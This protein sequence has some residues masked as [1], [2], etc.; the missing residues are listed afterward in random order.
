MKKMIGLVLWGLAGL[1]L[2]AGAQAATC[3]SKATGAWSSGATWTCTGTPIVAIPGATDTAIIASPNVVTLA[4][5]IPVTNLTVDTGA[6]LADAGFTLTIT[7]NLTNNGTI[8]GTGRMNVTGAASVIS[9]VGAYAGSRLYVSGAAT[10]IAAGAVLNFSGASR[11][12]VGRS[13][14]GT[15]VATSVLT[16]NGTINSTIPTA[17][18]A[19]LRLYANSTVIGGTGIINA[20]VSA[21][22]YNAATA[23][24]TN[25]GSVSVNKITQNAATNAWTQGVNSGLTVTAISTVGVLNASA[26]GN[27]VTYTSPATPIAPSANAY[28]NLAGTGVTCPTAFTILGSSPC[29]VTPGTVTVTMNPG[30]CANATGI[31][32]AAWAPSPTTNVNLSDALYATASINGT[33]NYLRCSGYGFAVP[34]TATILG[35]VVNVTRKSSS[36]T[37]TTDGAMRLVKGGAVGLTDRSTAT[38]YTTADVIEAHGTSADLWGVAWTPADINLAT[39]GAAFAAKSTKSRI[40]SVNYMPISVT[41]SAPPAAPHHIQIVHSGS[42][43]TCAPEQLTVKACA[44]AACTANFNGANVTGNVTWAGAPGGTLPFSLASGGTGQATISLSVTTAQTVTLGTSAVVPAPAA[45]SGCTNLAG[46]AACS[47][48]F[49]A[50][51]GCLDAVEVGAAVGTTIFTKLAGTAFSLDVKTVSGAN[52]GTVAVPVPV[53]VELVNASAGSCA[54]FAQLSAQ[55]VNFANVNKMTVPF[56]AYPSAVKNTMV[57]MTSGGSASCSSDGFAIRPVTLAITSSANADGTGTSLTATPFKSGAPFTLTA[58]AIAGYDG[59]PVIDNAQVAPHTGANAAGQLGVNGVVLSPANGYTGFGVAVAATGAATGSAYTYDEVGYFRFNINGVNDK[60]FAS[61]D[62]LDGDCT[63]DFSNTLVGGKYGCYFGNATASSYFGRFIPD[64]FTTSV[65][66]DCNTF[67]YSGQ[68]FFDFKVTAQDAF[69]TLT[70]NYAGSYAKTVT[71][72]DA[73]NTGLGALSPASVA[74]SL[75]A[76]GIATP[77]VMP[78]YTFTNPRTAPTDIRVKAIEAT[79]TDLVSTVT[80]A[81]GIAKVRSGRVWMSNAYGSELL[82]LSVPVFAQYWNGS[83]FV[84]NVDDDVATC[85][86][87]VKPTVTLQPGGTALTV[88]MPGDITVPGNVGFTAGNGSMLLTKPGVAGYADVTLNVPTWLQF[89]WS[90]TVPAKPAARATFGVYVGNSVF[91]YRGRHGR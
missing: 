57:R 23:Q 78:A 62:I 88:T 81:E 20:G 85:T 65:T 90:G 40:V 75:F 36:T 12:Y 50:S 46:G 43:K 33:S 28:Y 26:T 29:A 45:I 16:I 74:S 53:Q 15:T 37:S 30:S 83:A 2:S 71:L 14:A 18:T 68:P 54:T 59:I 47:L 60:S 39:F 25:N 76:G 1:M 89:A 80:G 66:M 86:S 35:I 22:T 69:G 72:S 82:D 21:I 24:V 70:Q 17:T 73:L 56:A 8:S 63:Q 34:A 61:L 79:G 51:T 44:D 38:V 13:A 5:T 7:G 27:T 10:T 52:L 77:A 48:P 55:N 58:T 19:F 84:T 11:I 64:H 9:G 42:G 87:F 6:T 31:G 49:V 91:V 32:T 4:G 67:V 3:T 41:Y